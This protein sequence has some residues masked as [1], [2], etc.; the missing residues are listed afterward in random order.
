M[1]NLNKM[2]ERYLAAAETMA[3][4]IRDT[5]RA[6]AAANLIGQQIVA[7]PD[8]QKMPAEGREQFMVSQ[9]SAAAILKTFEEFCQ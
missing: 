9:V 7:H 6:A 3:Q 1:L 8:F 4:H 2:I 5:Q